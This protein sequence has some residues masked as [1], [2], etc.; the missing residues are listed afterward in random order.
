[1]YVYN[2]DFK[3]TRPYKHIEEG[4]TT[5]RIYQYLK[6]QYTVIETCFGMLKSPEHEKLKRYSNYKSLIFKDCSKVKSADPLI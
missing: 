1:M 4:I 5:L 6:F 3:L 2:I